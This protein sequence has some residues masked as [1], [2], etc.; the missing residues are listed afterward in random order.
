MGLPHARGGVSYLFFLMSNNFSSSPRPWGCFYYDI[1]IEIENAVFPTPVGVFLNVLL[2]GL[3]GGSLP[4]ARGGVSVFIGWL[5]KKGESSPRPWGCFYAYRLK[6]YDIDVFPTPVGVFLF[7]GVLPPMALCLPH[8]RGGVSLTVRNDGVHCVSSP[9]PWGC[10]LCGIR[11]KRRRRVFPTPVGVFLKPGRVII[12]GEGSSPRPWGCFAMQIL[13]I[14]SKP[15]FPTPVGVFL[16]W[17]TTLSRKRGLPHARGGVS[18]WH[19][20]KPEV[21]E[22]SPRP[23]GCFF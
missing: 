2:V 17:W 5:D 22:S 4:H 14:S 11:R 12:K 21:E 10:F 6:Y 23:W 3:Y 16:R 18:Y 7:S 20:V 9:R 13:F 15:V 1:D 8:A 19:E